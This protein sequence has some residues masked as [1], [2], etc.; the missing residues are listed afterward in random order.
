[1]ISAT[2]RRAP[3][4]IHP[5][6]GIRVPFGCNWQLGCV[7]D[8]GGSPGVGHEMKSHHQQES[9]SLTQANRATA[10]RRP[11]IDSR[12]HVHP[13]PAFQSC[14]ASGSV[15]AGSDPIDRSQ[16][17]SG[18]IGGSLSEISVR[19]LR[20]RSTLALSSSATSAPSTRAPKGGGWANSGVH[21]ESMG[22][23]AR[24]RLRESG[25]RWARGLLD[26]KIRCI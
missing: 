2:S 19:S 20:A 24:R 12:S 4:V 18:W 6:Q 3:T 5:H 22:A 10:D 9:S 23:G 7:C 16:E 11:V 17:C 25:S 1:M 14:V 8:A 13:H 21:P 26:R 15:A